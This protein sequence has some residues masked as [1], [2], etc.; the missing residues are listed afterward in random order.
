MI[1]PTKT[2]P[3]LLCLLLLVSA[4]SSFA[5]SLGRLRGAAIV[6]RT[7]DVSVAAQLDSVESAASLCVDADVYFGDTQ[8]LPSRVRVTTDVVGDTGA[9][10][11]H[12]RTSATID[13]PVITLYVREGCNQ[14]NTRKYVILS[15]V[16]SDDGNSAPLP[17]AG[18]PASG[19]AAGALSG[20]TAPQNGLP[21]PTLAA[22]KPGPDVAAPAVGRRASRKRAGGA[23]D[24][25]GTPTPSAAMRARSDGAPA[26]SANPRMSTQLAIPMAPA[27]SGKLR[28]GPATKARGSHLKLDPLDLV[29]ERDPVLH[30]SSEMLSVPSTDP[31]QRAAAAALWR[32]LNAQP[33]DILRDAER[34][35]SLE[36]D[37]ASL[38]AQNRQSQQAVTQLKGELEKAHSERYFNWLVYTLAA[39]AVAGIAAALVLWS[40]RGNGKQAQTAAKWWGK[41]GDPEDSALGDLS[42]DSESSAHVKTNA[43]ARGA[44]APASLLDVDLGVDESLFDTLKRPPLPVAAPGPLPRVPL[45]SAWPDHDRVDF[46]A[47]LPGLP[48]S[49]NAEELFDVQQQA[50]FFISLGQFD[51]AIEVLQHHITDNVET[52]ALAYLDL[53]DLYHRLNRKPEYESLRK[54]FNR[55]FNAQVPV[56]EDYTVDNEGLD[57]YATALSRIE[58]LWPSPKVLEVIEESIFR[59]PA[60]GQGEA[61]NLTAYRELLLLYSVAKEIVDRPVGVMDFEIGDSISSRPSDNS[62]FEYRAN[63]FVATNVQPL[64][65]G[66]AQAP[67]AP[68]AAVPEPDLTVP[69]ASL[70]LGLDVDLSSAFPE[71]ASAGA[72]AAKEKPPQAPEAVDNLIDFDM[73][74]LNS[75][76]PW[77]KDK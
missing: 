1:F 68:G 19:S 16:L 5:V 9:V 60:G 22:A 37:V 54:D 70:R 25:E 52:S 13:E 35:K 30:S 56:F 27:T 58:S 64:P 33:Q 55:V 10:Q 3:L 42:G 76:T 53:L 71:P 47:S 23:A 73:D 8:V 77:P 26:S 21:A 41:A 17:L 28:S 50:D 20:Q 38:L 67:Q 6:G 18:T 66:G 40:R 65:V 14:K 59:N 12:V 29:V 24:A 48:R 11:I 39:L 36:A 57:A 44:S 49:V 4:A 32:A 72:A 15:D 45:E 7:L 69:P 61:F 46:A 75:V 34:L 63:Q 31:A 43:V 74:S 62:G 51:Q 2:R